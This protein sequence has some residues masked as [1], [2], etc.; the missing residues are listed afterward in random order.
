MSD[1]KNTTIEGKS[2]QQLVESAIKSGIGD[3][4]MLPRAVAAHVRDV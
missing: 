2:I 1:N 3:I 4:D